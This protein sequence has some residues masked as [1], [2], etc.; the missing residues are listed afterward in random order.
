MAAAMLDARR[1]VPP[2]E[3]LDAVLERL[4]LGEVLELL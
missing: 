3:R 2:R 4:G 1:D